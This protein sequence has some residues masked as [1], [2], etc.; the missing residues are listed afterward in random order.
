MNLE[1]LYKDNEFGISSTD[2]TIKFCL[3]NENG[4]ESYS[5]NHNNG[6]QEIHFKA[7]KRDSNENLIQSLAIRLN[8][9]N[10]WNRNSIESFAGALESLCTLQKTTLKS[11]PWYYEGPV[12][13]TLAPDERDNMLITFKKSANR[14]LC[15][16]P[17]NVDK[18]SKIYSDLTTDRLYFSLID[19]SLSWH[20]K[21]KSPINIDVK[22]DYDEP[23]RDWNFEIDGIKIAGIGPDWKT[24]GKVP[25]G[26][27]LQALESYKAKDLE[28]YLREPRAWDLNKKKYIPSLSDVFKFKKRG[29]GENRHFEIE[30]KPIPVR[31]KD[32]NKREYQGR[33]I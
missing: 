25:L 17:D 14:F 19:M 30:L 2:G 33:Y 3:Q 7:E 9:R 28:P 16:T 15:Y 27:L 6:R 31:T 29:I 21:D 12:I 20:S 8:G 13:K 1:E 24:I 18:E 4:K 22:Y 26:N 23:M 11:A 10:S 5:F 32:Q